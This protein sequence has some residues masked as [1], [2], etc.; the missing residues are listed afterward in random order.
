ME[1]QMRIVEFDKYCEKC[2]HKDCK[3][4]IDPCHSCLNEPVNTNSRKPIYFEQKEISSKDS[5]TSKE[6]QSIKEK[7]Q[8]KRSVVNKNTAVLDRGGVMKK[9]EEMYKK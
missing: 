2:K 7:K 4:Y 8:I 1:N 5:K 9:I 6:V 3:E